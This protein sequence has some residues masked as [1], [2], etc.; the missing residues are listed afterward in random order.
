VVWTCREISGINAM[1][2]GHSRRVEGCSLASPE[3]ISDFSQI[4]NELLKADIKIDPARIYGCGESMGSQ[5]I[6]VSAGA[7]PDLFTAIVAFNPIVDLAVWH[8]DLKN[9]TSKNIR[10]FGTDK[11]VA[12]E[13]GGL[14]SIVPHLYAERSA[15]Q[16]IQGLKNIPLIIF[17]SEHDL[18]VPHQATHHSL[19]LYQMIKTLNANSPIAE[20]NHTRLHGKIE[21]NEKTCF[22]L[23][24][25]CDYEL[26]LRW[27]LM[28]ER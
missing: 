20:Y 1:P 5:E 7:N 2:H 15:F 23:H 16:Y 3:Q 27:L 14:P 9:S 12:E 18:V 28:H 6:L 11:R 8:K 21:L 19:K 10:K 17:W 25:W 22:Q 4:E 13:V 26:A 24:E